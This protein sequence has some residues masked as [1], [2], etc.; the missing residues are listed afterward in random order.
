MQAELDHVAKCAGAATAAEG[1]AHVQGV[2]ERF[3]KEA[4]GIVVENDREAIEGA[5]NDWLAKTSD[6]SIRL[7]TQRPQKSSDKVDE[8]LDIDVLGPDGRHPREVASGGQTFRI[9][10]GIAL[11]LGAALGSGRS[12][13][14]IDEGFGSLKGEVVTQVADALQGMIGALEAVWV[15]SHVQAVIDVFP[16]RLLVSRSAAGATVEV[17]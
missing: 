11:G 5:A 15:T 2:L 1:A 13:L 6:L 3:F 16:H 12:W 9:D 7:V 17:V 4:P 8:V 10:V 14:W